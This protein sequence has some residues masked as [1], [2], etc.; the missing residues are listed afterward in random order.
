[1]TR[2]NRR[3][4]LEILNVVGRVRRRWRLKLLL[5]GM[6]ITAGVALV[7]FL[8]S[9]LGLET[10]R[11]QPAA[12]LGFRVVLW[13]ATG[14]FLIRSVIWPLFRRIS[15][16]RV[17][18]YLE[19]YEPSLQSQLLAAVESAKD[20]EVQDAGLVRAIIERAVERVKRLDD[21]R[22]IERQ[23]IRRSSGMLGGLTLASVLLIF[24]GP[25]FLQHGASALFFP[26]E[27][28]RR[29]TPTQSP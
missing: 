17:A 22:G 12:I 8:V 14:A 19:E 6:A 25:S 9:A 28:P 23:A 29:S 18:L 5:R 11:F 20:G 2:A 24:L 4:D 21:A 13:V 3:P 15:D 7:T 16:E 27:P 10:L 1:M 26:L